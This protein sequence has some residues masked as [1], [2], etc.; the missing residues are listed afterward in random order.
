MIGLLLASVVGLL[1]LQVHDEWRLTYR[2]GDVPKDML[3]YVQTSPDVPLVTKDLTQLSIEQTGDMSLGI[4]FD[5]ITSWPFNWYIRDFTQ[6]RFIGNQLPDTVDAPIILVGSDN[7]SVADDREAR[8]ITTRC[9]S[10]RCAGGSLRRTPTGVSPML[11]TSMTRSR[12]NYQ[13][14]SQPPYSIVDTAMSVVHTLGSMRSPREQTKMFR[15][16][17][18][19]ELPAQVHS[20]NF[21]VYIRNDLLPEYDAIR[22][23]NGG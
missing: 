14:K 11:P 6:R 12:Q 7:V 21:R 18:Y 1:L 15:L 5:D 8:R 16:L 2:E 10:I 22:Y 9:R 20:T 17:A 13:D 19:R 3:I 4:W 23:R